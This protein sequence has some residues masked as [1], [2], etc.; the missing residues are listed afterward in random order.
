M[1]E[2]SKYSEYKEVSD[3]Y[4][5]LATI[6]LDRAME[7]RKYTVQLSKEKKETS[8]TTYPMTEQIL[9]EKHKETIEDFCRSQGR[10]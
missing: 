1:I 5:K 4:Y 2:S 6:E 8:E 9:D 3:V 7:L 10:D